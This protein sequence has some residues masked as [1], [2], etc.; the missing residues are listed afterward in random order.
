VKVIRKRLFSIYSGLDGGAGG[1]G[2]AADARV[3]QLQTI[4]GELE[5]EKDLLKDRLEVRGGCGCLCA[6]SKLVA[7]LTA[8]HWTPTENAAEA[9]GAAAG[10][11]LELAA[12]A[13]LGG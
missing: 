8:L 6:P 11:G 5:Q 4:V 3:V 12:A 2:G 13:C 10:S 1:E 9:H 7:C